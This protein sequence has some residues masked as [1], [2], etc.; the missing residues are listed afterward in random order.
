MRLVWF[1]LAALAFGG[2][3]W[4]GMNFGPMAGRGLPGWNDLTAPKTREPVI[5]PPGV[6]S[7]TPRYAP[8]ALVI[9]RSALD[10]R[11]AGT[12]LSGSA[13]FAI[14]GV[15]LSAVVG[16]DTVKR[17][18]LRIWSAP[19]TG[20]GSK[21][22]LSNI[23]RP[24]M[25]DAKVANFTAQTLSHDRRMVAAGAI[26]LDARYPVYVFDR[27]SGR[28]LAT[29]EGLPSFVTALAFSRDG[30][31]LAVG[32]NAG[33]LRFFRTSDWRW[34]AQD[35]RY[36]QLV[37]SIDFDAMGRAAAVGHD[38]HL[39]I[40]DPSFATV[41]KVPTQGAMPYDVAFSPDGSQ[42]AVGQYDKAAISIFNAQS[43]AETALLTPPGGPK[44]ADWL[45]EVVWSKDG[46]WLY[47]AGGD[48][49]PRADYPILR[50]SMRDAAAPTQVF[51]ALKLRVQAAD[52][53]PFGVSGVAAFAQIVDADDPDESLELEFGALDVDGAVLSRVTGEISG[54]APGVMAEDVDAF[55]VNN[56]GTVLELP[57]SGDKLLRLDM[58]LRRAT[59]ASNATLDFAGPRQTH[60]NATLTEWRGA[61]QPKLTSGLF[62]DAGPIR[63]ARELKLDTGE[64]ALAYAFPAEES[65]LV[66]ATNHAIRKYSFRGTLLQTIPVSSPAQRVTVTPD[67]KN[68]VAALKDGTVRWYDTG[69]GEELLAVY[70]AADPQQWVAWTPSGFYDAG[71]GADALI[72]WQVPRSGDAEP[73]F[74]PAGTFADIFYRP[75]LAVQV[76]RGGQAPPAPPSDVLL[77]KL[78]PVVTIFDVRERDRQVTVEFKVE[79]PAN[80]P[81]TQVLAVIDGVRMPVDL[82]D[83]TGLKIRPLTLDRRMTLTFPLPD[84]A[85]AERSVSLTAG[86]EGEPL[87]V[88]TARGF[89]VTASSVVPSAAKRARLLALVVGVSDYSDAAIK[90]LRFAANDAREIA[91]RLR[92]Q[93]SKF[94]A[95][96]DV[97]ELTEE[98]ATRPA[99]VAALT[100]L[101]AMATPDDVVLVFLAG[102]GVPDPNQPEEA[103]GRNYFFVSHDADFTGRR[104]GSTAVPYSEIVRLVTNAPGRRMVF[105]D[106]CYAGLVADPD[107]NGFVNAW[108]SKGVYVAAATSGTA[109]AFEDEAWR[110]GAMTVALLKAFDGRTDRVTPP[111]EQGITTELLK[112][113]LREEIRRLTNGCQ[114]P[115]ILDLNLDRF[116]FAAADPFA[117]ALA[118]PDPAP[119][120]RLTCAEPL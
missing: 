94:Y 108:G 50:W 75:G 114:D 13:A 89:A 104:L 105:L 39:R 116:A 5:A 55:R 77:A 111:G 92:N 38:G 21:F 2:L 10:G 71:P 103:G 27:A 12:D 40:Y 15:S 29:I 69:R 57:G 101:Q 11:G 72:G 98:R 33:G 74:Y 96:V 49:A 100:E 70:V 119:S 59:E 14:P 42:I 28:V 61:N 53:T 115:Q 35:A 79:S 84:G 81:V 106:T 80:R 20:I 46:R 112:P 48:I 102:H 34:V 3:A 58:I 37:R 8:P 85:A 54:L 64:R 109:L 118:T 62:A 117:E 60:P 41:K 56:E 82:T 120:S 7:A 31:Y 9:E 47:G 73:L 22:T 87:G 76:L 78:P 83:D 52:L 30:R 88:A 65:F 63:P 19:E 67:G 16:G 18:T 36:T 113:Y 43:G 25:G 26:R 99:I 4:F 32:L 1:V 93:M 23:L 110:H 66:L 107:I 95:S 24:P 17:R 6:L 90:D 51:N 44:L 91:K 45:T 97:R 86:Y 68:V